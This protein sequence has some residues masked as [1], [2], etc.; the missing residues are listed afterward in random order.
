[1][2][3]PEILDANDPSAITDAAA[4]LK[5]GELVSFPTETVYG[6]GAD[7][8]NARAVAKIYSAK[9]RPSFNPLIAHLADRDAAQRQGLFNTISIALADRFWPGPL[10]LVVPRSST[11]TVS[12]STLSVGQVLTVVSGALSATTAQRPSSFR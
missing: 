5:A 10:T 8:A 1:M 12:G 9:G 2:T 6:L 7:A 4:I 3:A 11:A